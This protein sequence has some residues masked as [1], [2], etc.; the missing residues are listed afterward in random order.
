MRLS[1]T[2]ISLLAFVCGVFVAIPAAQA[3]TTWYVDDGN[4]PG[5]GSGTKGD[6]FCVIQDGLD[7][8]VDGDTVSVVVA[9]YTGPG[10]KDLDFAGKEI[11][12]NCAGDP[13][14]CIID[15]EDDGHAFHF[16]SGETSEA[17]L[18]G[19][20]ITNGL[21]VSANGGAMVIVNNSNPTIT[22]CTF[23][24]NSATRAVSVNM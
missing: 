12:A 23:D 10:N 9:T 4:C 6:P 1:K 17:I 14:T 16:L 18:D 19:F 7:A 5:P 8:A 11:T 20:T 22:N 3:Q 13:G 15:C 2:T 24:G 21:V